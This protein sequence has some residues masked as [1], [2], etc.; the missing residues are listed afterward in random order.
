MYIYIFSAPEPKKVCILICVYRHTCF[1]LQTHNKKIQNK[2]IDSG[3]NV[4]LK[5]SQNRGAKKTKKNVW[6][7]L[8]GRATW[9]A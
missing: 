9:G 6:K 4:I 3:Q 2:N 8:W 5:H 7:H 1:H